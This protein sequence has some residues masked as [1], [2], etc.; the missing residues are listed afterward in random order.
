MFLFSKRVRNVGC[1]VCSLYMGYT[2]KSRIKRGDR[3]YV[4]ERENYRDEHGKVKRNYSP[5]QPDGI[6]GSPLSAS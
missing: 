2:A 3:V 6:N 5:T 1:I 4:Y